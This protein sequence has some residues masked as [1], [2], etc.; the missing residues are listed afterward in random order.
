MSCTVTPHSAEPAR[1]NANEADLRII[2]VRGV[3]VLL[4]FDLAELYGVTT[5]ALLQATRRNL[6]R[7]PPDFM[8]Q[9]SA[10]E[11]AALSAEALRRSDVRGGRRTRPYAFTE[12]GVAMASSVLRSSTAI[13]VN[14]EIMRAFVRLR[15]ASMVSAEVVRLVDALAKRVDAHD[16]VIAEL[17]LA[18]RRLVAPPTAASRPVG[19]TAKIE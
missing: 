10:P 3:S 7:F 6:E 15:R 8:F 2:V 4:D 13:S 11:C 5:K 14:I 12:Q 19:F 17:V 1:A 9:L 18:I 16:A